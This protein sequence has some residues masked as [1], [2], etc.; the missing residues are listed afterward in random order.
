MVKVGKARTNER[1]LELL[2]A[3]P[4]KAAYEYILVKLGE[5]VGAYHPA[6]HLPTLVKRP[7]G[8]TKTQKLMPISIWV[9]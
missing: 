6:Q 4:R 2:L 8:R 5:G 3:S 9:P 1:V 7:K